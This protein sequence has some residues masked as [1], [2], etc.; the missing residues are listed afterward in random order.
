MH[1]DLG[2]IEKKLDQGI[3]KDSYYI[4]C[5]PY[6]KSSSLVESYSIISPPPTEGGI[7]LTPPYIIYVWVHY[8]KLSSLVT[9]SISYTHIVPLLLLLLVWIFTSHISITSRLTEE[10][11]VSK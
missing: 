4:F 9:A 6:A 8:L 1:Y 5:K 3:V 7:G 11:S 2:G 10:V